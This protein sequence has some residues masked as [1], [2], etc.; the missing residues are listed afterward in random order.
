MEQPTGYCA[1]ASEV[2]ATPLNSSGSS[3]VTAKAAP[4][5]KRRATPAAPAL[6]ATFANLDLHNASQTIVSSG[7][8]IH[9]VTSSTE[10]QRRA[11]LAKA[12]LELAEARVRMAQANLDLTTG[13]Q[14]GSVGR[15]TDVRC[16]GGKSARARPRSCADLAAPII[17]LEEE[18]EERVLEVVTLPTLKESEQEHLS[19]QRESTYNPS[20]T[21][22]LQQNFENEG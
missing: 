2:D 3:S 9:S 12:Q 20:H 7:S 1:P 5:K 14:A 11:Q 10:R 8:E 19:P 6:V 18:Y 15:L 16:E 22:V 17:Q 4:C 13:S 21:F